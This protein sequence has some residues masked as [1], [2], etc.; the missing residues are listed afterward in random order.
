MMTFIPPDKEECYRVAIDLLLKEY[1]EYLSQ[2]FRAQ[3]LT[4]DPNDLGGLCAGRAGE[5]ASTNGMERRGGCTKNCHRD[6]CKELGLPSRSGN[7][8][9]IISALGIDGQRKQ[10]NIENVSI[11]PNRTKVVSAYEQLRTWSKYR[12]P[13]PDELLCD[14]RKNRNFCSDIT[15]CLCVA[16]VTDDTGSDVEMEVPLHTALGNVGLVYKVT[17][18]TMSAQNTELRNMKND[19]VIDTIGGPAAL[20]EH[21]MSM[22]DVKVMLGSPLRCAAVF[23][24]LD[25]TSQQSLKRRI[26]R[27]LRNNTSEPRVGETCEDYI[28]RH[29]NRDHSALASKRFAKK[30]Q[31]RPDKTSNGKKSKSKQQEKLER[32]KWGKEEKEDEQDHDDLGHFYENS[33]IFDVDA[34]LEDTE[35][36]I[37]IAL[38][39]DDGTE[40]NIDMTF[41]FDQKEIDLLNSAAAEKSEERVRI[42]REL[43]EGVTVCVGND[44]ETTCCNC[45]MFNRW[46]ICRHV[47]WI[48][49]LHFGKFPTGDISD[50]E[51]SWES[52]RERILDTIQKK[53]HVDI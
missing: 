42:L 19:E 32:D 9:L 35:R 23:T 47:V 51:D 17:F 24:E 38:A 20:Q 6:N 49:V 28:R 45:E 44:C 40:G 5:V 7:P 33:E 1:D 27:R 50:A 3:Y 30:F 12:V 36:N 48:E 37:E 43:G 2:N 46:R 11:K 22:E 18:P 10:N 4:K 16:T 21:S 26:H 14:M 25:D 53:T 8:L 31:D 41:K 39:D 34:E 15:Y 52:I 13:R 29:A